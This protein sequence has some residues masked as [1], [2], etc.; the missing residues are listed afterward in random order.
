MNLSEGLRAPI[1]KRDKKFKVDML[2]Q[3]MSKQKV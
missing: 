3:F 1:R 2:V